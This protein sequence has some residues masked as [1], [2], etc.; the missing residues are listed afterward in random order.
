ALQGRQHLGNDAAPL[1]ERCPQRLLPL[2]EWPHALL[3]LGDSLLD[4][5]DASGAFDKLLIELAPVVGDRFDLALEPGL[6]LE[7]ASLLV[8][9]RLE[10]FLVLLERVELAW[11]R[12]G[13]LSRGRRGLG[14]GGER[15]E[16]QDREHRHGDAEYG[17][18]GQHDL[19]QFRPCKNGSTAAISNHDWYRIK[20]EIVG[21]I[22]PDGRDVRRRW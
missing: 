2:V 9:Q 10:L 3:P 13:G 11:R 5:S 7:G 17:G 15:P 8:A 22:T 4:A 21:P 6:V 18:R 12:D 1:L 14:G 20:T 16:R 19:H